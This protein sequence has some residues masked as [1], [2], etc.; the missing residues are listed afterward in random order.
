MR[1]WDT[2]SYIYVSRVLLALHREPIS[3]MSLLASLAAI[4]APLYFT[5]FT[6]IIKALY[7]ALFTDPQSEPFSFRKSKAN[8]YHSF[9]IKPD[10]AGPGKAGFICVFR[11]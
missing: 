3:N 10:Q 4:N 1:G 7:S 5:Y 8:I 2:R 6:Y 11:L 9:H